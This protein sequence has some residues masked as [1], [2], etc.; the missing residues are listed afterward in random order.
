MKKLTLTCRRRHPR[1]MQHASKPN[2]GIY[3]T[4]SLVGK[5]PLDEIFLACYPKLTSTNAVR[6][7]HCKVDTS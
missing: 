4:G 3:F 6:Q 1:R 7:F 5:Q 2:L